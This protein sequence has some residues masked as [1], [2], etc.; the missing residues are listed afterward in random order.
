VRF[1]VKLLPARA[2]LL[3]VLLGGGLGVG[4]LPAETKNM[5]LGHTEGA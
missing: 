2:A 1:D 4:A 3:G 5:F